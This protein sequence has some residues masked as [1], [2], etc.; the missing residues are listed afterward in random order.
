M[1]E[2]N[3]GTYC[4]SGRSFRSRIRSIRRSSSSDSDT[5]NT[6]SLNQPTAKKAKKP[7]QVR[8][9]AL[10]VSRGVVD[11]VKAAAALVLA[12]NVFVRGDHRITS[13]AQKVANEEPLRVRSKRDHPW[14]SRGGLKLSH[15]IEKWPQLAQAVASKGSIGLDVGSST[16]G[17]TDVLLTN[18]CS[19]V[20][21][22][23]VGK[24]SKGCAF[25]RRS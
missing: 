11:D 20:Y 21:S 4:C 2:K 22:V 5:D 1:L 3:C 17:F 14:V 15:A 10:L 25:V 12:G 13:P 8:I 23:D 24:V 6:N 18:G 7:K 9:D 19:R 16:G